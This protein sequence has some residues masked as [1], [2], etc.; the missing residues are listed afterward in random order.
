VLYGGEA[1]REWENGEEST[2]LSPT[3][4]TRLPILCPRTWDATNGYVAVPGCPLVFAYPENRTVFGAYLDPQWRPSKE[5]ILDAGARLQIAPASFGTLSYPLKTT[6]SGAVVWNFIPSWHLKLNYTQGFRPPA[7]NNTGSNG[8]G[9]QVTGNPNIS[10]ES[11]DALQAELNA[12]IFKGERRIRELSFRLDGSYTRLDDL[13]Q[14][15]S[16][17]YANSG[18]RG[19]ASVEFL[20]QLYLQGGHRLQLGYTWLKGDTSDKGPL[21]E[22]PEHWFDLATVFNLVDHKL[23]ATTDLRITG[24]AEDPNRLVEYRDS[25]FDASGN[26]MNPV[27]VASTD[28][29]MDRIPPIAELSFGMTWTPTKKLTVR[30]MIY[31]AL[32]GQYYQPDAFFDYEPHLEYLPNPFAS[33]RAYLSALYTY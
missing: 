32:V 31:N 6:F 11:S 17:T 7:F 25:S 33:F 22:L 29:V 23:T 13:I 24:A 16:G 2:F 9:L 10:V 4:L 1:F 28:L 8:E 19:L 3:D 5:L 12:R 14:V 26:V 20:G 18:K 21:R 27:T 30:G 15:T